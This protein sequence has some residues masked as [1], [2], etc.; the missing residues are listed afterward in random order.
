MVVHTE[1][2]VCC[3]LRVGASGQVAC[4]Y[5]CGTVHAEIVL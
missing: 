1:T 2:E 4:T 5:F 3:I